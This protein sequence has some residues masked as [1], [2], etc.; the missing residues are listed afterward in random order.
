MAGKR[1]I[2]TAAFKAQVALAALKGD[3]TVNELAGHYGVH[4]TL[5]HGWKKQ[6]LDRGGGRSSAVRPR[7]PR[8]TPR[9]A[10]PSCSSRSA[11]SR[12][13]WSGSKK[14][15]PSSA[16]HK[17]PLIEAGHPALSVRRQCELLGLS[18]SSLYYEPAGETAENLRLMRLIDEQYTA[19]PFYGSRR[20]TAWL[21]EQG[22][23]V[24]RKRV[25]R[26]MRVMGLEAIYPK[27]R[28]SA[29]RARAT[30]STRTCCGA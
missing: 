4:P 10:R 2:H 28:L 20:M 14:K 16:E 23:E 21:I 3:R 30:G 1:K 11:G 24:N 5:I 6:L 29:G 27:P 17:R 26:L 7:R 9:P 18:R 15:L 22:E 8:P 19:R 13:S 25:Q 12:W